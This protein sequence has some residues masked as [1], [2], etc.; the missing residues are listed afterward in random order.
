[1]SAL[2]LRHTATEGTLCEGTSKGDGSAAVLRAQGFRWGGRHLAA[3][4]IRGTAGHPP[5]MP[6]IERT[7]EALR[8]A[9]FEVAV[10]L[11][12]P[13]RTD[14]PMTTRERREAR[15]DRL[16]GWADKRQAG[17]AAVFKANE[18]YRGDHAFNFQPGH[19]PERAR[20]IART[21]R[22]F[23]S[24]AKAEDMAGRADTIRGQ[25]D[26]SIYSD[27]PDA[28]PRLRERIAGLEAERDR[29]KAYNASCRRGQRDL[30]LLDERQRAGLASVAKHSA[31]QL[32]EGGQMPAY[33]L[34]NL[35]GD[36]ARQRKR[37]AELVARS[38]E[39]DPVRAALPAEPIAPAT[40]WGPEHFRP[41]D[42]AQDDRGNWRAVHRVRDEYL[43]VDEPDSIRRPRWPYSVVRD[44]RRPPEVAAELEERQ[45]ELAA[46]VVDSG[47]PYA[48]D[49]A[50]GQMALAL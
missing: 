7:A 1:M 2:T 3:W 27:D 19:I 34:A 16:E 46:P 35:S 25:L 29:I 11:D 41:G 44:R 24:V 13:A 40:A 39:A 4:Y 38:G 32:G 6:R 50:A 18:A 43:E 21:E 26:S 45:A 8:A 33:K 5:A 47:P 23:K 20:V 17:A 30:S 48:I 37:L 28:I 42:E 31:Y 10:D 36:I 9:G 15:A 12:G 14:G 22:A 49:A